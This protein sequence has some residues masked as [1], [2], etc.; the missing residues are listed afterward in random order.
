LQPADVVIVGF[1]RRRLARPGVGQTRPRLLHDRML[2]HLVERAGLGQL[3]LAAQRN[4]DVG[5]IGDD[6]AAIVAA[7]TRGPGGPTSGRRRRRRFLAA[8]AALVEVDDLVV[9]LLKPCVEFL[10]FLS[11]E[12]LDGFFPFVRRNRHHRPPAFGDAFCR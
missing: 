12:A 9:D 10:A 7:Q 4:H 8:L 2:Q 11:S 6:P 1:V 5:E 3:V